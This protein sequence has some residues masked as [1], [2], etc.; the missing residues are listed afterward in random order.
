VFY[1][2]DV[3]ELFQSKTRAIFEFLEMEKKGK[4]D[5]AFI[6]YYE[7]F[8]KPDADC[9]GPWKLETVGFYNSYSG[10]TTNISEGIFI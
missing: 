8:I 2:A 6:E 9:I 1:K 5:E 4:W 7:S 10:L 3:K